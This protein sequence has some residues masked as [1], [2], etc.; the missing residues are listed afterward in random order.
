MGVDQKHCFSKAR[1]GRQGMVAEAE[2]EA[3]AAL[4]VRRAG[5]VVLVLVLVLVLAS[6]HHLQ[7]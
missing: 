7:E 2:A 6:G 1:S 4:R 3:A 5:I